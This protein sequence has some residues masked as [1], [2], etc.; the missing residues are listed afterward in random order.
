MGPSKGNICLG[1]VDLRTVSP[2]SL[3]QG[4]SYVEQE[5]RLFQGTIRDN[6]KYGCSWACEADVKDAADAA[7]LADFAHNLPECPETRLGKFGKGLSGGEKQRVAIARAL[8][9]K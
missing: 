7:E 4:I 2:A 5:P 3:R 1:D 8:L 6:I 9:R